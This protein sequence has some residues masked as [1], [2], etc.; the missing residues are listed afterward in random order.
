[1]IATIGFILTVALVLNAVVTVISN[2]LLTIFPDFTIILFLFNNVLTFICI[3]VLFA[4]I[5]KVLPDAHIKLRYIVV[6]SIVTAVLFMIG[7]FVIGYYL[8]IS[9][10]TTAYGTAASIMIIMVWVYYNAIILYFGAEFTQVYTH[11][12][13]GEIKPND[14]AVFI[15]QRTI[16][17]KTPI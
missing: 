7:K 5:F 1:M 9:N 3:T 10:L 8:S 4:V 15:E 11:F 13:G 16:E 12:I 17:S 2:R 14:Y 6:G